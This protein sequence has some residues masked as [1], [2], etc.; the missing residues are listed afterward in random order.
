MTTPLKV[1]DLPDGK[2]VAVANGEQDDG[3]IVMRQAERVHAWLNV[4]PHQGRMLNFAPGRLLQTDD[5]NI[6]CA[7]H[8]AV[9]DRHSG[10]CIAGPCKGDRLRAVAVTTD[11]DG[12]L[13]FHSHNHSAG[14]A[15]QHA[16]ENQS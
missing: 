1:A 13:H 8:G 3:L 6:M 12:S 11:A 16:T 14:A 4:C 2:A 7:A 5:G 15:R 9:F 10:A